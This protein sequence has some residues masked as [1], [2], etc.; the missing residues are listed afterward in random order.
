MC[1]EVKKQKTKNDWFICMLKCWKEIRVTSLLEAEVI[2]V[3]IG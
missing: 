3:R 1:L 2:K